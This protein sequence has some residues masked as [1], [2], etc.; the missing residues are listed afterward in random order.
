MKDLEGKWV[1]KKHWK[2]TDPFIV[3][4]P[5][6]TGECCLENSTTIWK[7]P[8]KEL[9]DEFEKIPKSFTKD[10]K[11][12]EILVPTQINHPDPKLGGVTFNVTVRYHRV[13]DK[14]VRE[15]AGGL[16]IHP[17]VTGEW[18]SPEN[19]LFREKNIPVK[20]ACNDYQ[21][22]E[23]AAY[24]AEYYKQE[25]VMFYVVSE[26]VIIKDFRYPGSKVT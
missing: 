3:Y 8:K 18:I 9:L 25:A 21:M 4:R 2:Y 13:W 12:W 26:N 5:L 14:K 20:I 17:V 10:T 6:E 22:Y 16:T 23:I 24:T 7:L 11:L 19:T 1:N 15:I